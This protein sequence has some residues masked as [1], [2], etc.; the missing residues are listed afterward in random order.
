M[1]RSVCMRGHLQQVRSIA[2]N[3]RIDSLN[4]LLPGRSIVAFTVVPNLAIHLRLLPS[5]AHGRHQSSPTVPAANTLSRRTQRRSS[6]LA[7][8]SSVPHAPTRSRRAS[9]P[10]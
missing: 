8:F 7:Q 4:T 5:L 1:D 3:L 9:R 10:A 2:R 6:L